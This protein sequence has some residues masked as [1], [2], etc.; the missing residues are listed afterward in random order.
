M[1]FAALRKHQLHVKRSKCTFGAQSIEY[2]GHIVSGSGVAPDPRKVSVI[3]S[4][5]APTTVPELRSFLGMTNY[6]S[7]FVP[8]YAHQAAPLTYL[9][10]KDSVWDWTPV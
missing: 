6:Y 3:E 5:P 4:W 1:V 2:L 8:H 9:L 7:T 10:R